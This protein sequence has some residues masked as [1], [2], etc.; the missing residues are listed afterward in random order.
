ML[1]A[2]EHKA[3]LVA[4]GLSDQPSW[5]VSLLAWFGPAYETSKFIARAK[6]ILG[7]EPAQ[8]QA[9]TL[10]GKGKR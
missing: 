2:V 4:G 10:A 9:P 6:M 8:K 3:L 7:D 1:V 5:F